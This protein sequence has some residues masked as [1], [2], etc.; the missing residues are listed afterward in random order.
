[1][2]S[3][4]AFRSSD[5]YASS[6]NI[7]ARG[8]CT[9]ESSAPQSRTTGS[10]WS[11]ARAAASRSPTSRYS[12]SR[13][14]TTSGELVEHGT[15]LA[16]RVGDQ[17]ITQG[18][19]LGAV[20]PYGLTDDLV[21]GSSLSLRG[22]LEDPLLVLGEPHDHLA[23]AHPA[24][25]DVVS[26]Q[27]RSR[28]RAR[29]GT[30]TMTCRPPQSSA[31]SGTA[32]RRGTPSCR[33]C[34]RRRRPRGARR[35]RASSPRTFE[36]GEVAPGARRSGATSHVSASG[37]ARRRVGS[38]RRQAVD[39]ELVAHALGEPGR[40]RGSVVELVGEPERVPLVAAH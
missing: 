33:A 3:A 24:P 25:P 32:L 29:S 38:V 5:G 11:S 36:T 28:P 34:S 37:G 30:L 20:P 15:V 2:I 9:A 35:R 17:S 22:S 26:P 23:A 14:S 16:D 13:D 18:V 7:E 12:T 4:A 10:A 40:R 1:S 6:P 27:Y 21:L 39:A 31:P 8:R 19:A